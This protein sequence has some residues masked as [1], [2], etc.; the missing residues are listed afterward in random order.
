MGAGREGKGYEIRLEFFFQL[1][2]TPS[3]ARLSASE[4]T[5]A[6]A[7]FS[8][9]ERVHK[10]VGLVEGSIHGRGIPDVLVYWCF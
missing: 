2:V 5:I 1:G 10:A 9:R 7:V 6:S 8:K 4:D 3:G